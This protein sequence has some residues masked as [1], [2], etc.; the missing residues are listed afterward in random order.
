MLGGL[1]LMIFVVFII[2][3]FENNWKLRYASI[4][5]KQFKNEDWNGVVLKKYTDS[6]NHSAE[7]FEIQGNIKIVMGRDGTD[8][9]EFIQKGDSIVKKKNSDT[10]HVHRQAEVYYFKRDI[11]HSMRLIE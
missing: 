4:I 9:F 7:T 2:I 5:Y 10:V 3:R 1:V 11:D 6:L 8:F